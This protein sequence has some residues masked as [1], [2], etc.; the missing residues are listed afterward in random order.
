MFHSGQVLVE[1]TMQKNSLT[2]M[3]LIVGTVA[4]VSGLAY[5]VL[6][7]GPKSQPP[8]PFDAGSMTFSE[9]LKEI[10][11]EHGKNIKSITCRTGSVVAPHAVDFLVEFKVPRCTKV[12]PAKEMPLADL[13]HVGRVN[14]PRRM[15]QPAQDIVRPANAGIAMIVPIVLKNNILFRMDPPAPLRITKPEVARTTT[16]FEDVEYAMRLGGGDKA[17]LGP[18]A[19]VHLAGFR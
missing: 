4:I 16:T 19:E 6:M 5:G 2:S 3:T 17:L 15:R 9:L 8:A 13:A 11:K 7:F 14:F 18:A 1:R 10:G 12:V